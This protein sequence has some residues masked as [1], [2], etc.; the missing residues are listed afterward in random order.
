[1]NPWWIFLP[2]FVGLLMG[3]AMPVV[4]QAACGPYK[5]A[6]YEH[7][8]LYERLA[9]GTGAGIDK[10]VVDAVAVKLRVPSVSVV[11]TFSVRTFGLPSPMITRESSR[12]MADSTA[13]TAWTITRRSKVCARRT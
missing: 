5:V 4:A 6:M 2:R 12:S 8:V 7:G 13:V 11:P 1:M 9:D 10:D 3:A